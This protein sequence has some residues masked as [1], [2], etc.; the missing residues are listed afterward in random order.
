M[1]TN[2]H[3]KLTQEIARLAGDFFMRNVRVPDTLLTVTRAVIADNLTRATIFFSVL[4]EHRES[5]ALAIA[6]RARSDFRTYVKERRLFHPIPIFD[7]DIDAGEK[8]RQRVDELT[9]A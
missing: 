9:R 8:N 7:F 2:R 1:N 5:I 3:N 4:P 6:K